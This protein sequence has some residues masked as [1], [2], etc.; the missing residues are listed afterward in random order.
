MAVLSAT[1]S[2]C[3]TSNPP[4]TNSNVAVAPTTPTPLKT[5]A[6][7]ALSTPSSSTEERVKATD[8]YVA[9][10]EGKLSGL[11][12]KERVLKPEELKGV[13]EADLE[14]LHAYYDGQ[15]LKRIKTYPKGS[16]PKTEEFYFHD[17]KLVFVF[18]EPQGKGKEGDDP[19]A[20]G[21]RL[22][23]DSNG[24]VAWYGDDGKP[25]DSASEAFKTKSSKMVVEAVAFRQLTR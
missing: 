2:G 20:K 7:Q 6:G 18:V 21:E 23:F 9:D 3:A 10:V 5:D 22:Y 12:R 8:A 24:L 19:K 11:S 14:K 25:K 15:T 4:T 17:D 1:L 16:S 13:T